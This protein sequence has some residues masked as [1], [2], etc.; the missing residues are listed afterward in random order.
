M[1]NFIE[2]KYK[3]ILGLGEGIIAFLSWFKKRFP[4]SDQ[5]SFEKPYKYLNLRL[6]LR[7]LLKLIFPEIKTKI[8]KETVKKLKEILENQQLIVCPTHTMAIE[9]LVLYELFGSVNQPIFLMSAREIFDLVFGLAE[10]PLKAAGCFSVVRGFKGAKKSL[11][12]AIEILEKSSYPLILFPEGESSLNLKCLLPLKKGISYLVKEASLLEKPISVLF[13]GFKFNYSNREKTLTNFKNLIIELEEKLQVDTGDIIYSQKILNLINHVIDSKL[14][15]FNIT[16]EESLIP[17]AQLLYMQIH[18][19]LKE[20]YKILD[21]EERAYEIIIKTNNQN[22]YYDLQLVYFW[23]ELKAL[24]SYIPDS[25][26]DNL[27]IWG[28]LLLKI[29]RMVSGDYSNI[30][31]NKV[32][33]NFTIEPILSNPF[34]VETLKDLSID[35]ILDIAKL[36]LEKI[37]D[38]ALCKDQHLNK[39]NY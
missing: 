1:K 25:T 37:N 26:E 17:K 34:P 29:F 9:A 11:K 3:L 5:F 21:K 32:M 16:S 8:S 10:F 4:C 6:I 36:E 38:I 33:K 20:K 18:K 24:T 7:V 22:N 15:L 35:E 31:I 13:I 19:Y 28:A 39:H 12:F 23:I 27:A 2:I 30:P 14:A